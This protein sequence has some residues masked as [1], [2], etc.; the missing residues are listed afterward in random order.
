MEQAAGT[1]EPSQTRSAEL[2]SLPLRGERKF[3]QQIQDFS[4]HFTFPPAPWTLAPWAPNG[5]SD[6]TSAERC[7]RFLSQ[8][9]AQQASRRAGCQTRK[10]S[11]IGIHLRLL[12]IKRPGRA[13]L[14]QQRSRREAASSEADGGKSEQDATQTKES[15]HGL[16]GRSRIQLHWPAQ[17]LFSQST[18]GLETPTAKGK[19]SPAWERPAATCPAARPSPRAQTGNAN[20][21]V[22][23][24]RPL[25]R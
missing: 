15:K 8:P 1:R 6:A 22:P 16:W 13:R 14:T 4:I 20:L 11:V 2:R 12:L 17:L 19:A 23:A 18:R 21:P 9:P 25:L 10:P 7:V 5:Y 3:K 24:P